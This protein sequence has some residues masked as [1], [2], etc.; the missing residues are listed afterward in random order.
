M[1]TATSRRREN[2]CGTQPASATGRELA[3]EHTFAYHLSPVLIGVHIPRF[4]LAVAA[5]EHGVAMGSAPL[6]LAPLDG[7]AGPIGEVSPAAAAAGV[8]PGMRTNQAHALCPALRLIP[9]DPL[10]VR[11]RADRLYIA[12]EGIG[13]AVEP[14]TD[15][16]ALLDARP[17]ERLWEGLEGVLRASAE[18]AVQETGLRPRLGAAPGRFLTTHAARRARPGKPLVIPTAQATTFLADLPVAALGPAGTGVTGIDHDLLVVLEGLGIRR[19]RDLAAL[20]ATVVR[21]RFG[22]EGE[23]A[24][25]LAAGH[26]SERIEPRAVAPALREMLALG[27]PIATEQAMAHAVRLLLDRGRLVGGARAAAR[28]ERRSQVA[29]DGRDAPADRARHP[30]RSDRDR[31]RGTHRRASPGRVAA[32]RGRGAAGAAGRSRAAG[33]RRGGQGRCAARGGG[34]AREQAARAALCP[35][36]G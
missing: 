3:I 25:L 31:A 14:V 4:D 13:A 22:Y 35:R 28:A 2:A 36:P 16:L 15:G 20:P 34:R 29:R 7:G 12:L 21:D 26:D 24:W 9:P 30:D 1:S 32:R 23:R 19:L 5:H 8:R 11:L 27:E 17:L 33:A 6:A 10:A 18:A